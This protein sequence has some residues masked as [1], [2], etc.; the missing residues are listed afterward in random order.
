MYLPDLLAG[1]RILITGG[2]TGLGKSL[3][4]RFAALGADLIICGRRADVL[5]AT[6]A[7][8]RAASPGAR[9][10]PV[11][12]DIRDPAAVDAMMDAIW[13]DGPLTTLVNNAA[14]NFIARTEKMSPRAADAILNVSLHGAMYCTLAAGKRWISAGDPGCV[15]S[16]L[17]TST[18]TGRAF[19]APSAMAKSGL[20]AM[21]RSLAVEWGPKGVR[22]AAIAPGL[23]PTE[24]AWARLRPA[25]RDEGKDPADSIPLKRVGRHGELADLAAFLVSDAGGYITGEMITIDGGYHLRSSGAEDLLGWTDEAWTKHETTRG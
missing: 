5:E 6:A 21:T 8:F 9:I 14:G 20:L 23:F 24:G 4:R 13:T 1:K 18:I 10:T 3:G 2:G 15:L 7:E 11:S 16:I 22:L 17:S 25:G 19:T 12:C